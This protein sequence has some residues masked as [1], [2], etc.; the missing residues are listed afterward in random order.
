MNP[1]DDT[2]WTRREKVRVARLLRGHV[3]TPSNPDGRIVRLACAFWRG[4]RIGRHKIP[5]P[6]ACLGDDAEAHHVDYARPFAV[7]WLCRNCHAM[8]HNRQ[9][10]LYPSLVCDYSSLVAPLRRSPVGQ[11]PRQR[12]QRQPRPV[13]TQVFEQPDF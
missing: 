3:R 12:K 5:Q 13:T 11:G 6:L 4:V 2:T 10:V 1:R 9:L 8:V 7:V